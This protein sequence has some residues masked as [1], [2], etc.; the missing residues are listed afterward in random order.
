MLSLDEVVRQLQ[1]RKLTMVAKATGLAYNTVWRVA[2]DKGHAVSYEVVKRL[3]DY[4][5]GGDQ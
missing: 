5:T 3:S 2:N 1:D 4:L